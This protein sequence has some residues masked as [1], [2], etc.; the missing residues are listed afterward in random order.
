VSRT[1]A[2][3]RTPTGARAR[4]CFLRAC[5]LDVTVRKPGNV[6]VVSPGHRMHAGQFIASAEAAATA[7]FDAGI[8]VG[9][10]IERAIAATQAAVGCNTNLGIV[11]LIAPLAAAAERPGALDST[12]ALH[13]ALQVVLAELD[14]ADAQAAYRAIALAQPAGLGEVPQADVRTVPQIGLREAMA[15]A[16]PRDLIARQYANAYADVF[17]AMQRDL[18]CGFLLAEASAADVQ[19][20]FLGWLSR[21]PDSHI[22]RK[23]GDAVAHSVMSAAQVWF[24][25]PAPGAAPGFAAWDHALKADGINPGTSADLTVATLWLAGVLPAWHGS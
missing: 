20:V 15:L 7:L 5:E 13:D 25:H 10:R 4:A 16:A 23:H 6:S 1:A 2:R 22:V 3:A 21:H 18:D 12:P 11:L 8:A 17:E 19:R 14:R 24:A 9:Q